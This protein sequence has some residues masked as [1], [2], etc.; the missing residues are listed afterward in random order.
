MKRGRR[1]ADVFSEDDDYYVL[2]S[3]LRDGTEMFNLLL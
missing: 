3:L 2:T 1:V